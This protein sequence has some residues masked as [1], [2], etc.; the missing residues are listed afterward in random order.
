M[1]PFGGFFL[2]IFTREI[3]F[4]TFFFLI[5]HRTTSEKGSALKRKNLLLLE[6]ILSVLKKNTIDKESKIFFTRIDSLVNVFI[7]LKTWRCAACD[8]CFSDKLILYIRAQVAQISLEIY[9]SFFFSE[10][11]ILDVL[12]YF[13]EGCHSTCR[14]LIS[15]CRY[16]IGVYSNPLCCHTN[17]PH[18]HLIHRTFMFCCFRHSYNL[19]KVEPFSIQN[20]RW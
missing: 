13:A 9:C 18:P 8:G 15:T 6:W 7:L 1:D 16:L 10:L 11:C 19:S 14:Y 12:R 2:A 3:T 5:W 20:C 17:H 4:S